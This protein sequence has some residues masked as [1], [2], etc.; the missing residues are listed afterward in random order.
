[1]PVSYPGGKTPCKNGVCMTH[2]PELLEAY[3]LTVYTI[4]GSEGSLTLHVGQH[5]AWLARELGTHSASCAAFTTRAVSCNR[6]PAT[7]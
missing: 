1:M 5:S 3:T 4:V 7:A 6:I 2:I